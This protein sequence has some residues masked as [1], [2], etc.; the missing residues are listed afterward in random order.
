MTYLTPHAVEAATIA[1]RVLPQAAEIRVLEAQGNR[2][3][4]VKLLRGIRRDPRVLYSLPATREEE[5]AAL[6]LDIIL[7]DERDP[8]KIRRLESLAADS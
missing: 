3:Q 4:L 8:A 5:V 1:A 6:A 2:R 7:D